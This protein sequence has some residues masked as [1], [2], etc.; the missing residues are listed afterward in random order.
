MVN[1][2]SL[3]SGSGPSVDSRFAS[4]F[5]QF[6]NPNYTNNHVEGRGIFCYVRKNSENAT[7]QFSESN[8]IISLILAIQIFNI[9]SCI[10][11]G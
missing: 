6:K 2:L 3:G 1:S 5:L 4:H 10:S 11:V 9:Y 8:I 7:V